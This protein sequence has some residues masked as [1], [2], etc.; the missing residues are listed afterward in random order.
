MSFFDWEV[1]RWSCAYVMMA[2]CSV[3]SMMRDL[4]K[5]APTFLFGNL[6]ILSNII[7]VVIYLSIEVAERPEGKKWGPGITPINELE[8]WSMVGFSV[9]TY[10]GIG[11]LLPIM[12]ICECPEK[13]DKIMYAAFAFLTIIY[14]LFSDFCLLIIGDNMKEPFV[15][16]QLDPPPHKTFVVNILKFLYSLNLVASYTISIYPCNR[17]LE[18]WCLKCFDPKSIE[19]LDEDA[20]A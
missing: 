18:E 7:V 4:T 12:N 8:Y 19:D 10:E 20:Y 1:D 11:M 2:I 13:F 5:L 6:M 15:I 3:A 14:I 16:Q 9:Y 17:I